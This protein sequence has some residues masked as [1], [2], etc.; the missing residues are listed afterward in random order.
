[1]K[2]S[3]INAAVSAALQEDLGHG[4]IT[5]SV[6]VPERHKSTAVI[7]AKETAVLSGTGLLKEVFRQLDP[8]FRITLKKADGDALAP[9]DVIARLHGRTRVMLA[10]ERLALNYL[11]YLSAIATRTKSF[12]DAVKPYR[13]RIMDTRKTTP[14]LRVFERHAV[15]CGGGVNHRF[16]LYDM[17]LVKDNHRAVMSKGSS[18]ADMVRGIR[19]KTK[20]KIEVE[21]DSLEELKDVLG[22]SPDLI[23][24]DNMDARQLKEAVLIT[25]SRARG[26]KR[27]LLEASGGITL[28]NV[29]AMAATGV[30]RISIGAL[31]H[32]RQ[33]VDMSLEV[34]DA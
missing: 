30:D 17:V 28:R 32:S 22:A 20:L 26:K 19:L 27:P 13:V 21:V 10:G 33:V 3:H 4:D 9:G 14:G 2:N 34:V 29:H 18:L 6:L 7:F 16:G 25:K 24:L 15:V 23:L 12:C 1:M 5:T 31:T 8:Q 11:S